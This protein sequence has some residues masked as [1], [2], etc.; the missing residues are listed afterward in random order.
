MSVYFLGKKNKEKIINLSSAEI[1]RKGVN[2]TKT[3]LYNSDPFKPH[4]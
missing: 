4:F 3:Y 2:I 1:A